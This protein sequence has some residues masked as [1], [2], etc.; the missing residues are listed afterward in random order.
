MIMTLG[1]ALGVYVL[2]MTS[3]LSESHWAPSPQ[4]P[5]GKDTKFG[6]AAFSQKRRDIGKKAA[7][8]YTSKCGYSQKTTDVGHS[9]T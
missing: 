3:L 9:E 2:H 5:G 1:K 4:A 8:E 6:T 7:R